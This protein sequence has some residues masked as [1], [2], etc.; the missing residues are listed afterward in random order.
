MPQNEILKELKILYVEDDRLIAEELID[1]LTFKAGEV[2]SASNG[3]EGYEAYLA[4]RPDIIITD[5]R[6]PVLD[7]IGMIREIRKIDE[8]V[9]IIITSA[10]N[11][12]DFLIE[13]IELHVDKYLTKP[14]NLSMLFLQLQRVAETVVQKKELVKKTQELERMQELL[15]RA[16]L[17][18]TSDLRGNITYVSRAFEEFTGYSKEELIGKNHS[19]F[20]NPETPKAFYE[21]M[22]NILKDDGEFVGEMKNYRKNDIPYWTRITIYPMFDEHGTKIGY[23]SY[24]EDIT[25]RK[26]LEYISCH[27]T[28]TDIHDRRHFQD[29]L[30]KR[31]KAA[32]RYAQQFGL[33]MFDLDHFKSINDTYGH[34]TGDEVL[35]KLTAHIKGH[36]REDDVFA[37]WGGE[38]FV[39][40]ANG[41]DIDHL[42]LFAA[43]LRTEIATIDFSPVERVT[44]S[45]GLTVYIKGDDEDSIQKRADDA[46]YLAKD[47]GRDTHAVLT[48]EES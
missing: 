48:G 2:V 1:I 14:I 31:I 9:P 15:S 20:R 34:A 33:I 44:I 17:F 27:D 29:E 25:D 46:L 42:E 45:L 18:T 6:M 4:H 47:Q 32:D 13:S 41:A 28:L 35:R 22:W 21:N 19:L 8:K 36:I 26:N 38:E 11:D 24:R 37:R 10:F 39:I 16:V 3:R 5:I 43:K 23:G 40:I 12:I 7:G 30:R